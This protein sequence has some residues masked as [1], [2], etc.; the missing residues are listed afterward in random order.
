MTLKQTLD[1]AYDTMSLA[2]LDMVEQLVEVACLW[3][4]DN[5]LDLNPWGEVINYLKGKL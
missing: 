5:G 3:G 4:L 2:W 1:K